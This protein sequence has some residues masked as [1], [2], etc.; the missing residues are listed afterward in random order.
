EHRVAPTFVSF[1]DDEGRARN[2]LVDPLRDSHWYLRHP[3]T[4]DQGGHLDQRIRIPPIT[5]GGPAKEFGHIQAREIEPLTVEVRLSGLGRV[6]GEELVA[7]TLGKGDGIG[8][9]EGVNRGQRLI[10]TEDSIAQVAG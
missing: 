1:K 8:T 9:L 2:G 7:K 5:E 4:N 3:S 10:R 6:V